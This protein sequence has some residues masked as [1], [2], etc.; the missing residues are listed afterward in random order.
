MLIAVSSSPAEVRFCLLVC[1]E[2]EKWNRQDRTISLPQVVLH[3]HDRPPQAQNRLGVVNG[4][5]VFQTEARLKSQA[6]HFR[7]GVFEYS[8]V[9]PVGMDLDQ[10]VHQPPDAMGIRRMKACRT[11]D[12]HARVLVG[13]CMD[14]GVNGLER[15]ADAHV[16]QR[17]LPVSDGLGS[18]ESR[19][20]RGLTLGEALVCIRAPW[21]VPVAQ[22]QYSRRK[23]PGL[24]FDLQP[25]VF[26]LERLVF[27]DL[28]A[29]GARQF[30]SLASQITDFSLQFRMFSVEALHVVDLSQQ[31]A[32]LLLLDIHLVLQLPDPRLSLREL[33]L[34]VRFT[35][36]RLHDPVDA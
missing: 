18:G 13:S 7:S 27:P 1:R 25:R 10:G 20:R 19:K 4:K 35:L 34:D 2:S 9:G 32:N 33:P 6:D 12:D 21:A 36:L 3:C 8:R 26:G 28:F 15:F 23:L 5:E 11:A 31:L 29:V 14:E 24:H 30:L 16:G 22:P 17:Q